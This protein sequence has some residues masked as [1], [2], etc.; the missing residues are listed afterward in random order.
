MTPRKTLKTLRDTLAKEDVR[1]KFAAT[2]SSIDDRG[3]DHLRRIQ[4]SRTSPSTR[5]K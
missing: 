1:Q 5:W 3:P 4:F 2:G